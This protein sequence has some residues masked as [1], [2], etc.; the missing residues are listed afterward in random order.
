MP[1][2]ALGRAQGV[3]CFS[4]PGSL[5]MQSNAAKS[6]RAQSLCVGLHADSPGLC[7]PMQGCWASGHKHGLLSAFSL[8]FP[9]QT[10][11]LAGSHQELLPGASPAAAAAL[12]SSLH[13]A[14]KP[15]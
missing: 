12:L 14:A 11:W 15:P 13:P 1:M 3:Q 6:V 9:S 5:C 10:G 8:G 2:L 4:A 7:P